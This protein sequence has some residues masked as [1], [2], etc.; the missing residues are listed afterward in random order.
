MQAVV[1]WQAE[2]TAQ[3]ELTYFEWMYFAYI[4][5]TTI[6]YGSIVPATFATKAFFVFWAL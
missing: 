4:S 2:I 6:G 5:L 3:P 1:F